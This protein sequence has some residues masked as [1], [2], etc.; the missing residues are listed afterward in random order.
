VPGIDFDR[1]R[2]EIT[3]E[4]VLELLGF[5]PSHRTGD[6][7]YGRCP[8]HPSASPRP[9]FFSVNVAIG[10]YHCHRCHSQGNQLELWA[11]FTKR[12]LYPASIDLC[13]L[14]ARDVPR[15]QSSR[16]PASHPTASQTR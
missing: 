14:L 12:K 11:A 5:V 4:Q 16:C 9:R 8:L 15:I 1:L 13:R 7:W 2:A 3:M 10:R 6:Q